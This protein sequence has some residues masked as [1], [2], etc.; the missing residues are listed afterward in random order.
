[1]LGTIP[2]GWHAMPITSPQAARH[3]REDPGGSIANRRP[4]GDPA[5]Y[6]RFVA[7]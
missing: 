1:M 7:T 2:D 6:E 5:D 4:S 3:Q